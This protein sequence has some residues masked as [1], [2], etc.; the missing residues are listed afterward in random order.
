MFFNPFTAS[1]SGDQCASLTLGVSTTQAGS[2]TGTL[3]RAYATCTYVGA[4]NGLVTTVGNNSDFVYAYDATGKLLGTT[5][6]GPQ[7]NSSF[8]G[9]SVTF[10]TQ[11][12]KNPINIQEFLDGVLVYSLVA[13]DPCLPSAG[14]GPQIPSG[15]VM[16]T[17]TCTVA[18]FD[19]P[20][21]RAL[22][23]GERITAGQHWFV[24][25]TP[26]KVTTNAKFPS[27]TEVFNGGYSDGF[28]PTACV[29]G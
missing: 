22:T 20:D 10:T 11:P 16:R 2:F 15:F 25:L 5:N 27:W 24:S 29:G 21:G 7:G 1:L 3:T 17:I 26:V 4:T 13:D 19:K 9:S 28:I 8:G 14:L 18:V 6:Y 23:T 12:T